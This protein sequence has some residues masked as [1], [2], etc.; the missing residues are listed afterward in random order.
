MDFLPRSLVYNY[1]DIVESNKQMEK[2]INDL[3]IKEELDFSDDDE[4][5][6]QEASMVQLRQNQDKLNRSSLKSFGSVYSRNIFQKN[7]DNEAG[8]GQNHQ[9]RANQKYI[10]PNYSEEEEDDEEESDEEE[11]TSPI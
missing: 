3:H 6:K 2:I 10:Q 7:R 11:V 4:E 5:R 8:T 1:E 9:N